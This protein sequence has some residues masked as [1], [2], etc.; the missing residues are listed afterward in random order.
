V[1]KVA[2]SHR[3][4]WTHGRRLAAALALLKDPALDVLLAPAMAFDHLPAK[5]PSVFGADSGVI[6][7][8]ICYSGADESA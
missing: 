4:R 6:C 7:Q 2:P 8:L 1:G 5:L 3:A